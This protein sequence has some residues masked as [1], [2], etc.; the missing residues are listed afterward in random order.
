MRNSALAAFLLLSGTALGGTAQAQS[1]GAPQL[2]NSVAMT[3]IA[4]SNLMAVPVSI[5]G[6]SRKFVIDTGDAG[7][8]VS[9]AMVRDLGLPENTYSGQAKEFNVRGS[10]SA[11][12]VRQRVR[13]TDFAIGSMKGANMQFLISGD[14]AL[15]DAK[16]Y[17]GL[18]ANDLFSNYDLDLDFAAKRMN[19]FGA[20][21]CPGQVAYWPE[22]PVAVVPV[23]IMDSKIVVPVTIDGQAIDAVIDTSADRTTMR[24][25]IA[26]QKFG[27]DPGT[28]QMAPV[29]GLHDGLGERVYV[30]TFGLIGFEGV[31][32]NNLPVLLQANS[33]TRSRQDNLT[34][35][36]RFH[37]T[38]TTPIPDLSIGMD[39]LHRLH[40]YIAFAE[41]KLYVSPAGGGKSALP[42]IPAAPSN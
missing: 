21:H 18:L 23:T 12:D 24:R 25:G 38:A 14:Q 42:G 3:Q 1:C 10:H 16:P 6:T 15:G 20:D 11:Q 30:H 32:V 8:Q 34:T 27:L 41:K 2:L 19:Y 26:E 7:T 4:G 22:K 29:E 35:G 36:S 39:V 37:S 28:P 17:D 13:I 31:A 33:M 9:Q 5:N 40:V